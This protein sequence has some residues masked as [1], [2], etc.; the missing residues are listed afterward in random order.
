M[1]NATPTDD[2]SMARS[3]ATA[4]KLE[5]IRNTVKGLAG[6]DW[7]ARSKPFRDI[8]QQGMD[9]TG[10]TNPLV[11]VEALVD[12]MS[13]KDSRRLWMIATAVEMSEAEPAAKGGEA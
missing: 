3:F 12:Q 2:D 4:G 9:E 7:E 6:K 11:I 1:S 8:I 5:E 13:G 10:V